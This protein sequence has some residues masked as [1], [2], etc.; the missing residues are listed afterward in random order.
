MCHRRDGDRSAAGSALFRT[1]ER[2]FVY[3]DMAG[4]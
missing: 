3:A 2:V 4:R 1:F